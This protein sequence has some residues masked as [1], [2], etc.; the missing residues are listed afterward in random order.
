[1]SEVGTSKVALDALKERIALSTKKDVDAFASRIA[2]DFSAAT[3]ADI[4]TYAQA[5]VEEKLRG[6]AAKHA[7]E[8]AVAISAMRSSELESGHPGGV[9]VA[10]HDYRL[11]EDT[12]RQDVGVFALGVVGLGVMITSSVLFGGVLALASPIAATVLREKNDRELRARA[13][14]EIPTM[15]REAGIRLLTALDREIDRVA[16]APS[17]AT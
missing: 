8:V 1:M 16:T 5:Y 13:A 17:T 4:R 12:F 6:I 3:A 15:V 9:H 7:D 11:E 14:R 2:T 10:H